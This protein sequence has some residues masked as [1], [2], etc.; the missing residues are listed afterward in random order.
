MEFM[1]KAE[2]IGETLITNVM[3][4]IVSRTRDHDHAVVCSHYGLAGH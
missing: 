3:I 2:Q 4:S 1:A